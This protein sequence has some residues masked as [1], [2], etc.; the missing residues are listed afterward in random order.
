MTMANPF[1]LP[2]PLPPRPRC[3]YPTPLKNIFFSTEF[4]AGNF[5]ANSNSKCI[6]RALGSDSETGLGQ[7]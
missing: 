1:S 6:F 7:S 5:L 4:L 2:T 3:C